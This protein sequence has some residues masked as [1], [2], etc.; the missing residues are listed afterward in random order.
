MGQAG[1]NGLQACNVPKNQIVISK[2]HQPHVT[3]VS[4]EFL[5]QCQTVKGQQ[6]FKNILLYLVGT[7]NNIKTSW[8]LV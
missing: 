1:V 2:G 4:Y 3:T 8:S 6:V 7:I 5:D